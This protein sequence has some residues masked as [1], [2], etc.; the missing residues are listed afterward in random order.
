MKVPCNKNNHGCDWLNISLLCKSY[1]Y[2]VWEKVKLICNLGTIS[3]IYLIDTVSVLKSGEQFSL[4]WR[5][6]IFLKILIDNIENV[7]E[8]VRRIILKTLATSS[9]FKLSRTLRRPEKNK[10]ELHREQLL[11][12]L[13]KAKLFTNID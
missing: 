13:Y 10:R 2:F 3:F 4:K 9:I 5:T 6:Y 7:G 12:R 11:N 8:V 1:L